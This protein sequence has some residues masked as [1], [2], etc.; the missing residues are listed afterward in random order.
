MQADEVEAFGS[1]G[2]DLPVFIHTESRN[3]KRRGQPVGQMCGRMKAAYEYKQL[4]QCRTDEGASG[5]SV[6]RSLV[7]TKLL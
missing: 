1:F 7:I 4:V 2:G 6:G 5:F 3:S